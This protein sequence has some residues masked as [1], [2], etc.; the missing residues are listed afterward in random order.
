V[1]RG[2]ALERAGG[3]GNRFGG[4]REGE[5]SSG[6]LLHGGVVGAEELVGGRRRRGLWPRLT[7]RR[8]EAATGAAHGGGGG[9]G[10][11][12]EVAFDG[13]AL[14]EGVA[15]GVEAHG[16]SAAG[17]LTWGRHDARRG[18]RGLEGGC[19]GGLRRGSSR[20]RRSA[21]EQ[22]AARAKRRKAS[23]L[24]G[25]GGAGD[26]DGRWAAHV[27]AAQRARSGGDAAERHGG[28][29]RGGSVRREPG[30][31]QNAQGD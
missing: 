20:R 4:Q 30:A 31:G 17:G 8:G 15:D 26:K 19:S 22:R 13:E 18:S 12:P 7:G 6:R 1:G 24:P 21:A 28:R 23:W 5:G 2:G 25:G 14:A 16:H 27:G 11:W 9:A 29:D 10:P 3:V